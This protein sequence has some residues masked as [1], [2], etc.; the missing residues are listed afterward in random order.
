MLSLSVVNRYLT[1]TRTLSRDSR[2]MRC[3]SWTGSF[4]SQPPGANLPS[5]KSVHIVDQAESLPPPFQAA[6]RRGLATFS[7]HAEACQQPRLAGPTPFTNHCDRRPEDD[8]SCP[9]SLP[10][11]CERRRVGPWLPAELRTALRAG[12]RWSLILWRFC[13]VARREEILSGT[14]A[15]AFRRQATKFRKGGGSFEACHRNACCAEVGISGCGLAA[16]CHW[17]VTR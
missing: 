12:T 13:F 17:D 7:C 2:T 10:V 11:R 5:L 9:G 8:P 15:G 4:W 3:P 16:L 1:P 6:R 14:L